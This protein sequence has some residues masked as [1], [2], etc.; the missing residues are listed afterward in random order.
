MPADSQLLYYVTSD[1]N[2]SIYPNSYGTMLIY[3]KTNLRTILLFLT[4]SNLLYTGHYYLSGGTEIWSGWERVIKGADVCNPNL[5][6]NGNFQVWQRGTVFN[7]S[8]VA[9]YTADGWMRKTSNM[10]VQKTDYGLRLS[11][12]TT[13]T[14]L[15]ITQPIDD[16]VNKIY[17]KQITLSCKIRNVSGT[18]RCALVVGTTNATTFD[19]TL[20]STTIT[21]AGDYSFTTTITTDLSSYKY[22]GVSFYSIDSATTN[23]I[24]IRSCKLEYGNLATAHTPK[25]YYEDL[26]ECQR[27]YYKPA[28]N[29]YSI[30][31][32]YITTE[33]TQIGFGVQFPVVMRTVPNIGMP[34][35]VVRTI[36]GYSPLSPNTSNKATPKSI[37]IRNTEP[38][39]NMWLVMTAA[40][41]STWADVSLTNTLCNIAIDSTLEFSAEIR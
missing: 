24:E 20:A 27:Y 11:C 18:W 15:S 10:I 23:L 26:L 7:T 19:A 21:E 3:K 33:S 35:V 34:S 37:F 2:T 41:G 36:N 14:S 5:L 30:Y 1:N 6:Y 9:D 25:A 12:G 17:S 22:V 8:N 32:G 16:F 31:N 29:Q 13:A 40:D 28:K 38:S 39:N 4:T